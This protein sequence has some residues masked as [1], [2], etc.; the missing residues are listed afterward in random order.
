MSLLKY[1]V[2]KSI[3]THLTRVNIVRSDENVLD[4]LRAY[5]G[6]FF[7]SFSYLEASEGIPFARW[8]QNEKTNE[9]IVSPEGF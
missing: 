2:N 8:S 3:G 4:R 5:S 7:L 1:K 6:L 9:Q